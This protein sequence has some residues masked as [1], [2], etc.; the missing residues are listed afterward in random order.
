MFDLSEM[1]PSSNPDLLAAV[2]TGYIKAAL[3]YAFNKYS[4]DASCSVVKQPLKVKVNE[5]FASKGLKLVALSNNVAV[6]DS[7]KVKESIKNIVVG[8]CFNIEDKVMVGVVKSHLT[9]PPRSDKEDI[10]SKAIDSFIPAF[11]GCAENVDPSKANSTRTVEHVTIKVGSE[12]LAADVPVIFNHKPL[13]A[14][15]EVVVLKTHADADEGEPPSKRS[16]TSKGSGNGKGKKPK[17]AKGKGR[18]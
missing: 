7:S 6:Q 8:E 5:A 1:E 14:G 17:K 13:K 11:W 2:H 3:L 10:A 16:R 4:M 15:D 18:S 12:S 9:L